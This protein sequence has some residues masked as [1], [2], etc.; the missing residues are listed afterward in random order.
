MTILIEKTT[1]KLR[2]RLVLFRRTGTVLGS[3]LLVSACSVIPEPFTQSR[4][5]EIAI[6]RLA[7]VAQEQDPV[8]GPIDLY[9]AMARAVK[10]NL[11]VKVEMLRRSLEVEQLDL[12]HYDLL[13]RLVA[14]SEYSNRNNEAGGSSQSLLPPFDESLEPSRSVDDERLFGDITLSWDILDFGLSYVRAKQQADEVLIAEENK[15]AVVNRIIEEVRVAYWRAVSAERLLIRTLALESEVQLALAN[16]TAL[17]KRRRVDPLPALTYR[18]ELHEILNTI[19]EIKVEFSS[20]KSELAALI[21][22]APGETFELVTP[23]DPSTEISIELDRAKLVDVAMRNRPELRQLSYEQRINALEDDI[24][25]LKTFPNLKGFIG[26]NFDTNSLLFNQNFVGW[27]ARASWNLLNVFSYP[28]RIATV[29]AEGD[30]IDRRAL[31]LTQA[32]ATQVDVSR[33]RYL[34]LSDLIDNRREFRDVQRQINKQIFAGAAAGR[35]SEQTKL[36][37]ELNTI[38]NEILYDR[39]YADLQAAFA[40]IYTSIGLDPFPNSVNGQESVD[41]LAQSFRE[42][43]RERGDFE[44]DAGA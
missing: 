21:N 24:Q 44:L 6:D 32:V 17:S 18:R 33:V 42:L 22:L 3:A 8:T 40:G 35:V 15:R 43:W 19:Q 36:R 25:L 26:F 14:N 37:E 10:Y 38:V 23:D 4:I 2:E 16:A 28:Q 7:R 13:P 1:Q 29:E 11:D 30:L 12:A 41:V 31:A 5:D 9:D 34:A 27:G 20:A 39:S